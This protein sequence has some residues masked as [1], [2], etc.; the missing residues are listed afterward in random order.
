MTV[1]NAEPQVSPPQ[2]RDS[3]G[4]PGANPPHLL[5]RPKDRQLK[6]LTCVRIDTS[7][8]QVLFYAEKKRHVTFRLRRLVQSPESTDQRSAADKPRELTR[9]PVSERNRPHDSHHCGNG[10][11]PVE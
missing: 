2:T 1:N 6:E 4:Q 5:C 3:P 9:T 11:L 8:V 10:R 7:A